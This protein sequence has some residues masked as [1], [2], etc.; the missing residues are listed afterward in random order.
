MIS[1]HTV[2]D[3]DIMY[4][5]FFQNTLLAIYVRPFFFFNGLAV[6]LKGTLDPLSR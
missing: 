2:A 1:S 3:N 5:L 4:I 6:T